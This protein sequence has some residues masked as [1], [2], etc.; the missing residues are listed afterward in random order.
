MDEDWLFKALKKW[1]VALIVMVTL[2]FLV[3]LVVF[4]PG[5]PP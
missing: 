2:M 5:P 4:T 1:H 3:G